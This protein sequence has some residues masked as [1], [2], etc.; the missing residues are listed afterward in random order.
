MTPKP[1][2]ERDEYWECASLMAW[3]A[4][5]ERSTASQNRFADATPRF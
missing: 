4:N 1:R 5:V 2:N 3:A